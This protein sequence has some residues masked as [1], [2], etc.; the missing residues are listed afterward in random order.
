MEEHVHLFFH[1]QLQAGT[2]LAQ[3]GLG[4][5]GQ[6]PTIFNAESQG[7]QRGLSL[8]QLLRDEGRRLQFGEPLENLQQLSGLLTPIGSAFGSQAGTGRSETQT[9]PD[10][11]AQIMAGLIAGGKIAAGVPPIGG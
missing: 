1:Q 4:G 9:T 7:A 11:F 2:T 5:I 3:L 8:D 6:L 10:R